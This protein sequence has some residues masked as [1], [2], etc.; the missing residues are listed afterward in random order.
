MEQTGEFGARE[1]GANRDTTVNGGGGAAGAA[2]G[3]TATVTAKRS[4]GNGDT[5]HGG[6]DREPNA[7]PQEFAPAEGLIAP[8]PTEPDLK[9]AV[10]DLDAP[11]RPAAP[12]AMR[13]EAPEQFHP[14]EEPVRRR[15]TVRERAPIGAADEG[16]PPPQTQQPVSATPEPVITEIGEAAEADRPRRTGWWSRRFA[17][18]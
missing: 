8:A 4:G 15:S 12:A 18:G 14:A 1:P 9:E 11:P 2:A 17:G 10:A 16:L 7:A 6:D 13:A 5:A 3:A